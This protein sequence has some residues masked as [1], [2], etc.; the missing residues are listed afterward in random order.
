MRGSNK[1]G[2]YFRGD[3]VEITL[4]FSENITDWTVFFTV[5]ESIEDDDSEAVIS[6]DITTHDL[7]TEG[8]T[9]FVLTSS[10]TDRIGS[11]VYD[12]QVK[13]ADGLVKTVTSGPIVFTDDVTE[14]DTV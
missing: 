4:N 9:T 11:Y 8:E 14:R 10:E 5:K 1:L 3:D 2:P 6:K 12:I 7:P 13:T